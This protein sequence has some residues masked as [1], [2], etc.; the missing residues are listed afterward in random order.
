MATTPTLDDSDSSSQPPPGRPGDTEDFFVPY[1]QM[2]PDNS[3]GNPNKARVKSKS[4]TINDNNDNTKQETVVLD[5]YSTASAN[6]PN[7]MDHKTEDTAEQEHTDSPHQ[8]KQPHEEHHPYPSATNTNHND[9]HHHHHHHLHNNAAASHDKTHHNVKN[10]QTSLNSETSMTTPVPAPSRGAASPSTSHHNNNTRNK[11]HSHHHNNNNNVMNNHHALPA[12]KRMQRDFSRATKWDIVYLT[13][14]PLVFGSDPYKPLDQLDISGERDAFFATLKASK[15][16]LRVIH[17]TATTSNIIAAVTGGCRCIH[18]S[19]HGYPSYLAFEDAKRIGE[20]HLVHYDLIRKVCEDEDQRIEFVFAS[21]CHSEHVGEAFIEAGIQHVV[22]VNTKFEVT[23]EAASVFTKHFYNTLLNG[24]T[25]EKSFKIAKHAVAAMSSSARL[26]YDKFLLLPRNGDHAV[27]IFS[28]LSGGTLYDDTLPT[29]INNLPPAVP[30]FVGR[31][32]DMRHI[33]HQLMD[34]GVRLLVLTGNCGIG[35][36][37]TA[38]MVARYFCDRRMFRGGIF[39]IDVR[40]LQNAKNECK[41]LSAMLLRVFEECDVQKKQSSLNAQSSQE[42]QNDHT[43][44]AAASDNKKKN[45]KDDVFNIIRTMGE[46]LLVF[47]GLDQF[48]LKYNMTEIE[49]QD[50]IQAFLQNIFEKCSIDTKV[51]VTSSKKLHMFADFTN[52][53][54]RYYMLRKLKPKDAAKLFSRLCNQFRHTDIVSNHELMRILE[55][56]P[57]Q[58]TRIVQI[59]H[60][61][62]CDS[63]EKITKAYHTKVHLQHQQEYMKTQHQMNKKQQLEEDE[64]KKQQQQQQSQHNQFYYMPQQYHHTNHIQQQLQRKEKQLLMEKYIAKASARVLWS[65]SN[66]IETVSYH[67][68]FNILRREFVLQTNSTRAFESND[69]IEAFKKFG[70]MSEHTNYNISIQHFNGI[71]EWFL[72]IIELIRVLFDEWNEQNPCAIA[73]FISR[74]AA[75]QRLKQQAAGTFIIRFSTSAKKS[76]AISYKDNTTNSVQHIK[77]TL[78]TQSNKFLFAIKNHQSAQCEMS[79]ASFIQ[80]FKKINTLFDVVSNI[81]IAKV[82]VYFGKGDNDAAAENMS[83]TSS[84]NSSSHQNMKP[85]VVQQYPSPQHAPP[86][87]YVS[88]TAYM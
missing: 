29:P 49:I 34:S 7:D 46:M 28:D 14:S 43:N 2:N 76:I 21:A 15:Q 19:G 5:T 41:S 73:G 20:T 35:K 44:N 83:T 58:I 30:S 88:H 48:G 74:E 38:L 63:L 85:H 64:Q 54:S 69:L 18:Y 80:K 32:I 62:H 67:E 68:I 56:N 8:S 87:N 81:P 79:L 82:D 59:K 6:T 84:H 27:N 71:Y 75:I 72:G 60:Q 36:S 16:K 51:L 25:I 45:D 12:K 65:E 11:H 1:Y 26:D 33:I 42:G 37:A 17:K 57:K 22:A 47:D 86:I 70:K 31:A 13:S 61:Y 66:G 9:D 53:I 23:D 24:R 10:S 78:M 3:Q 77:G 50:S 40:K 55:Y 52:C 4:H 39:F